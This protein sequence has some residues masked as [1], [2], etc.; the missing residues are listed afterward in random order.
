M[1]GGFS[2]TRIRDPAALSAHA[3]DEPEKVDLTVCAGLAI[4]RFHLLT[5]RSFSDAAAN[6]DLRNREHYALPFY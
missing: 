4:D 5:D 3:V 6:G 1:N 2:W